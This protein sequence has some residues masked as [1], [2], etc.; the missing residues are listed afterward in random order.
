MTKESELIDLLNEAKKHMKASTIIRDYEEKVIARNN[1]KL[2]YWFLKNVEGCNKAKH[3]EIVMTSGDINYMCFLAEQIEGADIKKIEQY[4][5]ASKKPSTS[6]RFAKNVKGANIKAHEDVVVE[7]ENAEACLDFA[8]NVKGAD[9][10]RLQDVV[11]RKGTPQQCN[12]FS[13]IKGSDIKVL[14]PNM[15]RVIK[16]T[17]S[18]LD[19]YVIKDIIKYHKD[20]DLNMLVQAFAQT[21]NLRLCLKLI[22]TLDS[23]LGKHV[24]WPD[25]KPIEAIVLRKGTAEDCYEY[26]RIVKGADVIALENRMIELLKADNRITDLPFRED[27]V[28]GFASIKGSKT[29]PLQAAVVKCYKAFKDGTERSYSYDA[30]KRCLELAKIKGQNTKRLQDIIVE[31]YALAKK[32]SAGIKDAAQLCLD[33]ARYV[34][35]AD[36]KPLEDI[37]VD[38]KDPEMAY[39]FAKD[40][41]G[42]DIKRLEDVVAGS[43]NIEIIYLF[44]KNIPGADKKHLETALIKSTK[45]LIDHNYSANEFECLTAGSICAQYAIEIEDADR[46]ELEKLIIAARNPEASLLYAKSVDDSDVAAH[47]EIVAEGVL[48]LEEESG[49]FGRYRSNEVEAK[50]SIER[51]LE[52]ARDVEGADVNYLASM[53]QAK[54]WDLFRYEYKAEFIKLKKSKKGVAYTKTLAEKINTLLES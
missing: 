30:A 34:K 22:K 7:S 13:R 46:L 49:I 35:G 45:N 4:V 12:K 54:S 36:I 50:R 8:L 47:Q 51:C 9:I 26:A 17:I 19:F 20:A 37:I 1:Y 5:L 53:A 48:P 52:F 18:E 39:L 11:A 40:V 44:A 24:K 31:Y 3:I 38:F 23:Y 2:S 32:I 43:G 10:N 16:N 29:K 14:Q 41:P 6:C 25:C 27:I 15:M 33:F 42:A 21:E 28:L